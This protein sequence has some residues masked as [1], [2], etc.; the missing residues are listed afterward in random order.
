M[1]WAELTTQG[2]FRAERGQPLTLEDFEGQARPGAWFDGAG[3]LVAIGTL[4]PDG[5]GRVQRGFVAAQEPR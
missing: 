3:R 1:P 2:V 5:I 4:D